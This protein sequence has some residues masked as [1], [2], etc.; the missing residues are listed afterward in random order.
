MSTLNFQTHILECLI[1]FT[2]K[3]RSPALTRKRQVIQQHHDIV[4]LVDIFLIT[5]A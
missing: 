1:Y 3:H 4:T 2:I 5:K